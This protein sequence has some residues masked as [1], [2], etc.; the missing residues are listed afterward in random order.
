MAASP[1]S[2]LSGPWPLLRAWGWAW[3]ERF[4]ARDAV[5]SGPAPLVDDDIV[6]PDWR[7]RRAALRARRAGELAAMRAEID[8]LL[9]RRPPRGAGRA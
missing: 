6:D 7:G 4:V 1:T 2:L 5:A 9:A 8:A 3:M